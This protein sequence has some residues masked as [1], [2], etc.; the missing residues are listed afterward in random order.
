VR[1]FNL[2]VLRGIA[3]LM[4]LGWHFDILPGGWAG[5]DLFF[6]LSGFLI[7][8]LLFSEWKRSGT[9][10]IRRFLIRRGFKIYP[11]FYLYL[12]VTIA[13]MRVG[14]HTVSTASV[15]PTAMFVRNYFPDTLGSGV[16]DHLWS[17][18]V[19]EQF[20]L[21]LP[22]MLLLL[23]RRRFHFLPAAFGTV[24]ILA[25][26]LRFHA[27]WNL[28]GRELDVWYIPTHLRIDSLMFG[29]VLSYLRAFEPLLFAR[30]AHSRL[31]LIPLAAA[32]AV[33]AFIPLS[34]PLMHTL[35]FTVLYL[36]FGALLLVM[37][38]RVPGAGATR[39]LKPVAEIGL[40]S[41]SIY[42]WHMPIALMLA[43]TRAL[44]VPYI[45]SSIVLGILAAKLI[46]LPT[47]RLRDRLFPSR[48]QALTITVA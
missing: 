46:E 35:G 21:V 4:V 38:V 42:L 36:G 15:L 11:A 24:A 33:L 14:G 5:V 28:S 2:D 48:S 17:L 18:A 29:A 31:T 10:D 25:M 32:I 39:L 37:L 22:P 13:A 44:F 6:V 3:V 7:S 43:H 19:E 34:S 45:A 16:W 27:G 26:V 12:A 23:A 8:S 20:Y 41:Y 1:N 47:L 9:L 40:N 30:I